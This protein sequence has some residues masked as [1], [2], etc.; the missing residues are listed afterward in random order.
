[1]LRA[2]T[3]DSLSL[4]LSVSFSLRR[5]IERQHWNTMIV[6]TWTIER[7]LARCF[8]RRQRHCKRTDPLCC[9]TLPLSMPVRCLALIRQ[10]MADDQSSYRKHRWITTPSDIPKSSS[11]N[12]LFHRLCIE[13]ARRRI[14]RR[15]TK[16]KKERKICTRPLVKGE[17][18]DKRRETEIDFFPRSFIYR[19]NESI[20]IGR[21]TTMPATHGPGLVAIACRCCRS[22]VTFL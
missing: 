10:R 17:G 13:M 1:M 6:E 7:N 20:E 16:E 9:R 5:S 15:G 4:S 2:D 12:Y 18:D 11:P 19:S 22:I 21:W 3:P 14:S 8:R